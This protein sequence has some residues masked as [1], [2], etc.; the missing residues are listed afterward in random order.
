[1]RRNVLAAQ[2][3]ASAFRCR[4]QNAERDGANG[5]CRDSVFD[6][7]KPRDWGVVGDRERS[8]C[9]GNG[10]GVDDN[11]DGSGGRLRVANAGEPTRGK[12]A[13]QN[14]KT[15]NLTTTDTMRAIVRAQRKGGKTRVTPDQTG[16]RETRYCAGKRRCAVR[17]RAPRRRSPIQTA[18][19][20]TERQF[21]LLFIPLFSPP[22]SLPLL[23]RPIHL[24]STHTHIHIHVYFYT[25]TFDMHTLNVQD[26]KKKIKT[27][28][29][30]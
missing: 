1:M 14:R 7:R 18:P 5:E 16:T 13:P 24:R 29:V 4:P 27:D 17:R 11:G 12:N 26:V 30:E 6:D 25:S 22:P 28:T 23:S 10:R 9:R 2:S 20:Y 19:P 21:R 15:T 8:H 3:N